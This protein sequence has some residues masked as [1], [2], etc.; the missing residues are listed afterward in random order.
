MSN[1]FPS[2]GVPFAQF[3]RYI[4]RLLPEM[5]GNDTKVYI[6]FLEEAH[7]HTKIELD[8]N[9]TAI[10]E[11]TGLS[12]NTVSASIAHLVSLGF[13]LKKRGSHRG[14]CYFLCNPETREPL[15]DPRMEPAGIVIEA[16]PTGRPRQHSVD[17]FRQTPETYT[18]FYAAM[19]PE[20][21]FKECGTEYLSTTCPFCKSTRTPFSIHLTDGSWTCFRCPDSGSIFKFASLLSNNCDNKKAYQIICRTMG[22]PHVRFPRNTYRLGEELAVYDYMDE[23]GDFLCRKSRYAGK[24]FPWSRFTSN[25]DVIHNIDG[26][27]VP[28]YNLPEVDAAN[29]VILNEG[30]KDCHTVS[31]LGLIAADGTK[32]AVTTPPFGAGTW[33]PEYSRYFTGKQVII[34]PHNDLVG[35]DHAIEALHSIR[36]H[37]SS[38]KIVSL[39]DLSDESKTG[40]DVSDYLQDHTAEQLVKQMGSELFLPAVAKSV[41]E[42]ESEGLAMVSTGDSRE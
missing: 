24:Q 8:L 5:N 9:R 28:I 36:R 11:A 13:L 7:A 34:L 19:L 15:P 1:V 6:Y 33:Y 20:S 32:V 29:L 25:G 18:N 39:Y 12:P 37:A 4:K 3:P 30:E 23:D 22:L 38:V 21:E 41:K 40:F 10:A 16:A 2:K 14:F 42:S 35:M 27:H 17:L 31:N 26:I